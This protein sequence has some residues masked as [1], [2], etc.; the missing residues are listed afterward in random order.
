MST[1]LDLVASALT[2]LGQLGQGQT[3]NAEDGALGFRQANLLLSQKSTQRLF[4]PYVAT[5]TY[6]LVAGQQDYTIGITGA[7]FTA[8]RP[9]MIESAQ[10]NVGST[11]VWLPISVFG[12]PQWDAIVNKGS[13]ADIPDGIYVEYQFPN[14]IFHVN[15]VPIATPQIKLGTWETLGQFVT[16][17]DQINFLYPYEEWLE[18]ALAIQLAPFYDAPISQS[19]VDRR[20]RA[21]AALTDFNARTIQGSPSEAQQFKSPNIGLPVVPAAPAPTPQQ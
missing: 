6:T 12:K 9:M 18:S 11:G 1:L 10:V 7:T 21:E 4:L 20:Q 14:L 19:L 8:T 5:R 13:K 15:P 3:A 2:S 17:Y 16:L